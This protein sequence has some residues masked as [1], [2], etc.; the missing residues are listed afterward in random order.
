MKIGIINYK[1][2]NLFSIKKIIEDL[3]FDATIISEAKDIKNF[4][5]YILPGVGSFKKA[6]SNLKNNN[7]FDEIM[8]N[9]EKKKLILGI[10][11]GMQIMLEEGNED[12]KTKG[13]GFFK[14]EVKHLRD[15][16]CNLKLPHIGWNNL[17][18]LKDH[19]MFKDIE[20]KSDFYFANNYAA[21]NVKEE[22]ISQTNY[23]I[24]LASAIAKDNIWGVQFHP[25]KSSFGGK[26][27]I[28][29]FLKF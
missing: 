4:D 15:I 8:N 11:L 1:A 3:D 17:E 14:G 12:G 6:M 26:M 9:V 2:G 13:F 29:N 10:C 19:P 24:V 28:S 25:E 22:T 7:M 23:D 18:I 21:T 20:N 5:K 27:L 16:G